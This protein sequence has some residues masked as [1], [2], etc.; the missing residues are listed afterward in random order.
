[1]PLLFLSRHVVELTL[2]NTLTDREKN[3]K[4]MKIHML[5]KLWKSAEPVCQQKLRENH[6]SEISDFM[7]F[8]NGLDPH[9]A[10]FRYSTRTEDGSV[11]NL[12]GAILWLDPALLVSY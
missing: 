3:P 2:K 4:T 1:M 12:N 8:L 11:D 5:Q 7:S 9:G 6:V 10:C